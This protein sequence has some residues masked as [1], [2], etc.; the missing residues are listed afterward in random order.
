MRKRTFEFQCPRCKNT[1]SMVRDTLLL[2]DSAGE[3]YDRLKN[4]GFFLHQCQN[5]GQVFPLQYPLIY[6]D[7]EKGFSIFLTEQKT[8]NNLPEGKNVICRNTDEF[9]FAFHCL[10]NGLNMAEILG[11]QNII[12][13]REHSSARLMGADAKAGIV[14]FRTDEKEIL[15]RL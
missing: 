9:Q 15:V 14:I 7:V 1:F 10:D 12:E 8:V 4:N 11:L 3:L 5:C 13:H 6:R 2:K